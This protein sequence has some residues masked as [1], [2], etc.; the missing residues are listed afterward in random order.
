MKGIEGKF[1]TSNFL[2]WYKSNGFFW[3]RFFGRGFCFKDSSKHRLLFSQRNGYSKYLKIGGW[4]IS[5]LPKTFFSQKIKFNKKPINKYDADFADVGYL[6]EVG[7][8]N[9]K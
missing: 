7:K 8:L 3:F 1:I 5:Y 9:S 4:I 2:C 6:D